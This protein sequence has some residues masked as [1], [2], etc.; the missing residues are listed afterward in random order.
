[1]GLTMVRLTEQVLLVVVVVVVVV[2][3]VNEG[4]VQASISG[5]HVEAIIKNRVA[6]TTTATPPS[7]DED[8]PS[9]LR[10]D[11]NNILSKLVVC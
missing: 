5:K 6:M 11:G 1:L 9:W 3:R 4:K 8:R 2:A 7:L 10:R